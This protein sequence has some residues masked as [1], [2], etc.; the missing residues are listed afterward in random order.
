MAPRGRIA[1]T[2][3][4]DVVEVSVASL[5]PLRCGSGGVCVRAGQE[6]SRAL[7][8]GGQHLALARFWATPQSC[9]VGT[10]DNWRHVIEQAGKEAHG[11][12]SPDLHHCPNVSVKKKRGNGG[13]VG[14][15]NDSG[16]FREGFCT[17]RFFVGNSDNQTSGKRC[18]HIFKNMFVFPLFPKHQIRGNGY[19]PRLCWLFPRSPCSPNL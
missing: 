17:P 12:T 6:V 4:H 10:G 18:S 13:T 8:A 16:A 7:G 15:P 2:A 3:N 14:T 1:G 11:F 19:G 9:G 5:A